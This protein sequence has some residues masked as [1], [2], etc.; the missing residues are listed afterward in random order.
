VT[1]HARSSLA[2]RTGDLARLEAAELPLLAQVSLRMAP[3]LAERLPFTLPLEPNGF[4]TEPS[5]DALWLG[6]DEWLLV[7][8]RGTE[9]DVVAELEAALAGEPHSVVDVSANRTAIELPTE[10]ARALLE[11]GCGLDLDPRSWREG[12]CAQT[13]F[14]KTQ[15]LLQHRGDTVR[16][17][18]RPSFANSLVDR[19]LAAVSPRFAGGRDG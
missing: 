3:V 15:V 6:P 19:L 16:I 17:F 9:D 13:L 8:P 11:T 18:V 12:M 2:D 10:P 4:T 14:A 1:D 5:K 7:A